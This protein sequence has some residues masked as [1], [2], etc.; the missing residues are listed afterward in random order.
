MTLP[1]NGSTKINS[2]GRGPI[3]PQKAATQAAGKTPA[4]RPPGEKKGL[5]AG[6]LREAVHYGKLVVEEEFFGVD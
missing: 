4:Q 6:N 2:D 3:F 1:T 5:R